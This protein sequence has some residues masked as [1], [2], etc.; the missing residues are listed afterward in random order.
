MNTDEEVLEMCGTQVL[1]YR[2]GEDWFWRGADWTSHRGS[3]GAFPTREAAV[4]SARDTLA[5]AH[6]SGLDGGIT[7][8]PD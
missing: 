8:R 2:G 3:H 5:P 6:P 1:I 4:G 7:R